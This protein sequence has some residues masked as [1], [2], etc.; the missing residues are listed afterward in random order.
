[1]LSSIELFAKVKVDEA[2]SHTISSIK[3][4]ME[5]VES[6]VEETEA[7]ARKWV[8]AGMKNEVLFDQEY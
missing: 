3:A 2:V 7:F 4:A 8:N 6:I 5:K 1:M